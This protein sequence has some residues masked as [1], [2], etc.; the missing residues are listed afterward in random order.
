MTETTS[1]TDVLDRDA[2]TPLYVQFEELIRR[3]IAAGEWSH[4]D[5]I[6]SENELERTYGLSRMTVRGV[7]TSLVRDGLLFRVPGKGTYVALDTIEVVAP[8]YRGLR[9]QLE[10][11][12]FVTSTRL[13]SAQLERPSAK[14][15]EQLG[16]A[17]GEQTYVIRRV[18]SAQG[19]PVSVHISYIPAR[20]APQ[21]DQH[22]TVNEQLCRVLESNYGLRM[23]H[24]AERLETILLTTDEAR[25]LET[26][27]DSP[28]L[29]LR[30][31]ISDE[32]QVVF[33]Y[34]TIIFRGDRVKLRFE[35]EL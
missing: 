3:K 12:E 26:P 27:V 14:I 31:R 19:V 32:H 9:E 34:S 13:L 22:D 25:L 17:A 35:Y 5:R 20:L 23:K 29:M 4:G 30:D 21:L 7:L 15:R 28:A 18:R 16:L 8:A 1:Q 24:V 11:M 33:E 2:P 10:S 6:P